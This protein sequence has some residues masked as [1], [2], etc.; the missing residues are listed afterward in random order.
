MDAGADHPFDLGR[1]EPVK[2][3]A[4][5]RNG[6]VIGGITPV[7]RAF[8]SGPRASLATVSLFWRVSAELPA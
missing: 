8:M 7:G 4:S 3:S 5:F 1:N 6:V 2:L